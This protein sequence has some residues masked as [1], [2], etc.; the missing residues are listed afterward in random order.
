VNKWLHKKKKV[1]LKKQ[2]E[3]TGHIMNALQYLVLK[4]CAL[5]K[6]NLG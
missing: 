1:S 5:K 6:L 3:N 2:N 4:W